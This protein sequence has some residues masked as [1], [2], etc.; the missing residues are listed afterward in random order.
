MLS[1]LMDRVGGYLALPKADGSSVTKQDEDDDDDEDDELSN[2]FKLRS[3][4]TRST[5]AAF[6]KSMRATPTS[7]RQ[8]LLCSSLSALAMTDIT[9]DDVNQSNNDQSLLVSF[10]I[11][12]LQFNSIRTFF[13]YVVESWL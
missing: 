9:A 4:G 3:S 5:D 13:L 11:I 8:L 1:R 12:L 6:D 2:L 7:T 10:E